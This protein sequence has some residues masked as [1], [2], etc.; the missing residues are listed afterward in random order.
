VR[1]MSAP[2]DGPVPIEAQKQVAAG[3]AQA[4]HSSRS[5][6]RAS[7]QVGVRAVQQHGPEPAPRG[8]TRGC[9]EPTTRPL[10]RLLDH[11]CRG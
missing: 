11:R 1:A 3:V 8:R 4:C 10:D 7:D 9:R 5:A 2:T 6:R